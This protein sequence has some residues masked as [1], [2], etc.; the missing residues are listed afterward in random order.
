MRFI[1]FLFHFNKKELKED[2][3]VEMF[4]TYTPAQH[5]HNR[6]LSLRNEEKDILW[7]FP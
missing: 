6:I 3:I 2:D 1:S 5:V 7:R 4:L